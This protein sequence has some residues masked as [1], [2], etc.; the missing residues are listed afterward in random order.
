MMDGQDEDIEA[1]GRIARGAALFARPVIFVKGVV[2]L[3]HLPE[4]DRREVAFAG[5][6]NVGKSSLINAVCGQKSLARTSGEPGRT[7]ELNFFTLHDDQGFLVDLP[8]YGFA[9]APK[10]VVDRWVRLTASY[11]KGRASLSRVF[12]L[13]DSRHGIKNTDEEVLAALDKAAVSYCIVLTK[14]D[15]LTISELSTRIGE[16][17]RAVARRPAA[18]PRVV[19][20]SSSKMLGIEELR[21]EIAEALLIT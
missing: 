9:R 7:R 11:L 2:G 20:T 4:M 14:T 15:K 5:R 18:F 3:Q 6:S 10:D 13:I 8:G 17:E 12:V 21:G 19:A 16:T 1:R